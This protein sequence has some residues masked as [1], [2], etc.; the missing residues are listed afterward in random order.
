MKLLQGFTWNVCMVLQ[1][2]ILQCNLSLHLGMEERQVLT[3]INSAVGLMTETYTSYNLNLT[4]VLYVRPVTHKSSSTVPFASKA[5]LADLSQ[6][7]RICPTCS[8]TTSRCEH[9]AKW[10]LASCFKAGRDTLEEII[11]WSWWGFWVLALDL[12]HPLTLILC[13]VGY[14]VLLAIAP[15]VA[16]TLSFLLEAVG[17]VLPGVRRTTIK[18]AASEKTTA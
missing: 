13:P 17:F 2:L 7:K 18:D 14:G 10:S 3:A 5:D 1:A 12:G 4:G 9:V 6:L 15:L 16:A 11:K 8:L